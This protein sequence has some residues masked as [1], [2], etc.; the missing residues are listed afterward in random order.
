VKLFNICAAAAAAM[1]RVACMWC[2]GGPV[3]IFHAVKLAR[4]RSHA[5]ELAQCIDREKDL[6][7]E[8]LRTLNHELTKVVVEQQATSQAAAEFWSW[9]EK[10]AGVQP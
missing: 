4:I 8:N 1:R 7:R 3:G 10:K 6:H 9:C 5:R 2:L